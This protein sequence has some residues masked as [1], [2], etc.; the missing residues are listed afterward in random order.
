MSLRTAAQQAQ[1]LAGILRREHDNI[2]QAIR[3][4]ERMAQRYADSRST[5]ALEYQDA[6]RELKRWK[7]ER[8]HGIGGEA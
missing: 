6:A 3:Y 8:A 2:E 7:V 4:A 5:M 1:T